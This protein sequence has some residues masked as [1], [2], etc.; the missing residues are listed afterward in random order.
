MTPEYLKICPGRIVP[1][2]VEIDSKGEFKLFES[3]AILRYLATT[4]PGIADHWYPKDIVKRS[5]VD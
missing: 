5:K 4:R 2:M 1:A 3:H